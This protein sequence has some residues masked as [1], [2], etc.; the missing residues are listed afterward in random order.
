[1]GYS[2]MLSVS[3]LYIVANGRMVNEM[4]DYK[5]FRMKW[6]YPD[7]DIILVSPWGN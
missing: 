2:M 6:S 5:G 1:M 4:M 3:A 7:Q